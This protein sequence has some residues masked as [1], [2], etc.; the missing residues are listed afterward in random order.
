MS[1][2]WGRATVIALAVRDLRAAQ[3]LAGSQKRA[4][5]EKTQRFLVAE[6]S[7]VGANDQLS[8]RKLQQLLG[9]VRRE[10]GQ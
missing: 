1:K 8:A 6:L 3:S 5:L 7:D 9:Q 10:L 4:A 2:E